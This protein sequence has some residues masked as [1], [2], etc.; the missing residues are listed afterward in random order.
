MNHPKHAPITVTDP[1]FADD[2]LASGTPVLVDFW[3]DWCGPCHAVAPVLQQIAAE[4]GDKLTVAKVDVDENPSVAGQFGVVSIPTM[5]LFQDGKPSRR[6][7]GATNKAILVH[8]LGD[9][10]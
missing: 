5:I 2:V 3:T 8:E 9:N 6:L 10:L 1:S 4:H 7:V